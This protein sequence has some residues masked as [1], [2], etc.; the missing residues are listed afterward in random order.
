MGSRRERLKRRIVYGALALACSAGL[1]QRA[2]AANGTWKVNS[3]GNW[4]AATNWTGGVPNAANDAATFGNVIT[5]DR[6]VTVDGAFTV[7]SLIFQDNNN[8]ILSGSAPNK[9]T[10]S[11]SSG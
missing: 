10:F 4:S 5:A 3:A 2:S 7:G 1:A 8:Y 6:I 9:L 11:H